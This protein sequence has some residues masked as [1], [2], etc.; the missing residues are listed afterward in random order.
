METLVSIILTIAG[1]YLLLGFLFAILFLSKG[2]T[3]V[4]EAAIDSS[5]GFRLLIL[6]GTICFWPVLLRKWIKGQNKVT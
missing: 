5:W 3:K 4:D 6:P 1:G 2:I